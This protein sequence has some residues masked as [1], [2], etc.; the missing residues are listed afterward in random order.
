[1]LTCCP[2]CRTCFR[3]TNVQLAV[4]QGKVRCGKCKTVFNARQHLQTQPGQKPSASSAPRTRAPGKV[5]NEDVEHI[6][7][8]G[9]PQPAE[10]ESKPGSNNESAFKLNDYSYTD[11][12]AQEKSLDEILAE[13]NQQLS[14]DIDSPAP[15]L[16]EPLLTPQTRAPSSSGTRSGPATND[17]NQTID[18]LFDKMQAKAGAE[19]PGVEQATPA[20]PRSKTATKPN[21][22][23]PGEKQPG[24]SNN[25]PA[26]I[27]NQQAAS[28][29]GSGRE[30]DI[31]EE[32]PFL[33]RDSLEI[34]PPARRGWR[35]TLGG[36]LLILL[37]LAGLALQ[38][39]LFRPLDVVQLV[40]PTMPYVEF[41]CQQLPC[42][43]HYHQD[44]DQIQ[45]LS[46]DVRAHPKQKNVLL[47]TATI[48]NQA[49]FKQP[50]PGLLVSL[51]DLSGNVVA[52]R[53]FTPAEYMGE[54]DSPFLLMPPQT[55]IQITL[56][57]K[58]PG[59]DAIN[60]EFDFK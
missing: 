9:M 20:R 8:Q 4:A 6:V 27:A 15:E 14:L 48:I 60:F 38:L 47:I 51:F 36:L 43:Y 40:P 19:E 2:A 33:L 46:R 22:R 21:S 54:L 23:Q 53:R 12:I 3:I 28:S 44:L 5:A 39:A 49:D 26:F 55:P 13:M 10:T 31:E 52:Q 34:E 30:R 18:H 56:E 58:D 42:Q 57:V 45:L 41:V 59:N 50:Y 29:S 32:V 1:M 17:R 35:A 7:I 37:L 16:P 24:H 25:K 11:K